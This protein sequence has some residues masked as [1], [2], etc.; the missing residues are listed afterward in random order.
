MS[1]SS[2]SKQGGMNGEETTSSTRD[3]PLSD[4][5]RERA[6]D[7]V[8]QRLG[9]FFKGTVS[10]RKI[11]REVAQE[12]GKES[13]EEKVN[14]NTFF[15]DILKD[16]YVENRIIVS[17]GKAAELALK[18]NATFFADTFSNDIEAAKTG[19]DRVRVVKCQHLQTKS[20]ALAR[21]GRAAAELFLVCL[22]EVL[23]Y[24]KTSHEDF[25][26][27]VNIG[28]VG[29]GS[30]FAVRRAFRETALSA[31][32]SPGLLEG[33][34][35]NFC[36]LNAMDEP[37]GHLNLA[38]AGLIAQE[39]AFDFQEKAIGTQVQ[40]YWFYGPTFVANEKTRQANDLKNKDVL[41]ITDPPGGKTQLDIV[42]MGAGATEESI[43]TS[44]LEEKDFADLSAKGW[45]GDLLC[46]PV[47]EA[48][49]QLSIKGALPYSALRLNTLRSIA[50]SEH[51][52]VIL[53][54]MN[55]CGPSKT[56][57][58]KGALTRRYVNRLVTS[59][60]TASDISL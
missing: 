40:C 28:V 31:Y 37:K 44:F 26:K 25:T 29:G 35:I 52:H 24:K 19:L 38:Q 9:D 49:E 30:C 10:G 47:N 17:V 41:A 8:C 20:D 2:I 22:N 57:A 12:L 3:A 60:Q 50:Q 18:L 33:M 11:A 34:T 36:A 16:A 27:I 7:A 51:R 42:L 14:V 39:F 46:C 6:K 21:L 15:W 32:V 58:I 5:D 13:S 59:E 54:A 23:A 56:R 4:A 55:D 48:G 1:K 43:F 45:V 53:V